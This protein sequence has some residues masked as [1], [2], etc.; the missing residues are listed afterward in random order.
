MLEDFK[1]F[2]M[3]G[4]V[5]DLA[6][7]IIIGAAFGTIVNSF[8]NDVLM[9]P[10]GLAL[11]NVDFSNLFVVL[12]EG[13]KAAG[14]YASLA[15]AKAAGAVTLNY[16]VFI[17]TIVSFL[18]IAFAVYLVV[19]AANRIQGPKPAASPTTKD[20]PY[21]AMSIPVSA[22]RCPHCTSELTKAA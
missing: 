4:N 8:V 18:I 19:R 2:I 14:P 12:K 21:C 15:D 5:L 17:N 13:A 6:V 10:I 3:R 1:A 7:G 11:G 16:G 22:R 20:C 9:P